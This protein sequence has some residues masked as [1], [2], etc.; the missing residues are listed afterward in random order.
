MARIINFNEL[1]EILR[2][3]ST[4]EPDA[5][6]QV[7][8]ELG[9]ATEPDQKSEAVNALI[10]SL[11]SGTSH[12]LL[13]AHAVESLGILGDSIA[14]AVLRNS[15]SDSYRL[16]R[17]YAAKAL[18]A[19]ETSSDGVNLLIERL[20]VESFYGARA[21]IVSTLGN[22]AVNTQDNTLSQNIR[23]VLEQ[24]LIIE[25]ATLEVGKERVIADINRA[26]QK[27]N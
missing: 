1:L 21:E 27:L 15:L 25:Q 16:V 10:E 26:L 19:L 8:I 11:R 4:T 18:S 3:G 23:E 5:Q 20:G 24:Q 12:A 13:R 22:I 6:W 17:A 2:N 7:A 14:L 9:T